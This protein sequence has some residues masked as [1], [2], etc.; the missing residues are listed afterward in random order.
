MRIILFVLFALFTAS[1]AHAGD[2]VGRGPAPTWVKAPPPAPATPGSSA[3]D[4]FRIELFDQQF[5]FDDDGSHAFVRTRAVILAPQAL[6]AF[7][8]VA[9]PWNPVT[10]DVVVHSLEVI[11]GSQRID[12]LAGKEFSLLR[13]EENLEAAIVDGLLTATLQ[14]D[15]LRVGDRVE[16]AYSVTTRVPVLGSHAE[17]LATGALPA[18]VDQYFLRGSWP[19][20][21]GLRLQ[22]SSDWTV[23]E[24]RRRGDQSEF[25]VALSGLEPLLIPDDAP[26]RFHFVRQI[27]GT[28]YGSWADLAA[29]F[30]PL[31]DTAAVLAPD[32]PLRTE[33]ARISAAYTDPSD[34]ALAALRLVQD[35]VRYL[36]LA[37]GEG[38]LIPATADETWNRRLGD[39]KGKTVLLIALL[40]ELGIDARPVLVSTFDDA[41]DARLPRVAAF[42]HVIVRAEV[43]GQV[44]W[45][46][47]ARSG[48]RSLVA[49]PPL[50]YGWVLPV[51]RTGS[52][53]VRMP[54]T[55]PDQFLR[56]TTL[57]FDL[58]G[59]LYVSGP[60][61]GEILVRGDSAVA[62]QSQFAVATQAQRDAYMRAT[63]PALV[64]GLEITEVG[65]T[66]DIERNELRWSMTGRAKLDW[67]SR[68]GRRTEI[69][70]SRI[71]W[72]AGDRRPEGPFRDLPVNTNYPG[73]SR[74]RTTIILPEDG[75][76]FVVNAVDID[77]EAAGYRHRRQVTRDG[78]RI[79]ME[80]STL[81]LRPEMTEAERAAAV[82]PLQRLGRQVAEILAPQ[83]YE[84]SAEDLNAIEDSEPQTVTDWVN[85]GLA[86]N[87]NN[88][89]AEAIA[90]FDR[91]IAL[92][93]THANAYAN[94]GI[95]RFWSGDMEGAT[96]DF[97]KA[98]ELNPSERVAMNG[99]GMIALEDERYLDAVVEFT[100]SLRAQPDDLFVLR[101][102]GSAYAGMQEWDKS[103]AD[104]A[105][106]REIRPGITE[107]DL[108]EVFVLIGAERLEEAGAAIDAVI[109]RE[110][111]SI[112]ALQAQSSV[113]ELRGDF[114]GAEASLSA[115]LAIE[116][117]DPLLLLDRA[118][119]RFKL[120]NI[121]GGRADLAIV[122]PMTSTSATLLNNICWTQAVA[123]VDLEQALADCDAALARQPAVAGF[124]DSR[125]LVLLHLGRTAEAL[126]VY[127][128]ALVIQPRQAA[129][130]YGRGLAK[131]VLG[132]VDE[133]EADRRAAERI[134]PSVGDAFET[135]ESRYP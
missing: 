48:D 34:R 73:Y 10:Q 108:Q 95:V 61:K 47:G 46:D 88:L 133:G 45:L 130:L 70:V 50:D 106:I 118:G 115:A 25:E 81:V 52:S 75:E 63:W 17:I 66:Y 24:V 120:G 60:V 71:S 26:T 76:G 99:R 124:L 83:S 42:D 51:E 78:A 127:E 96:A 74:F 91:A 16:F 33:I 14:L 117:D 59:G 112:Q 68:G 128:Q 40:R 116:R 134:D 87:S 122:R 36:A 80:R 32:S 57:A 132:R 123:G 65:S 29:V 72:S 2:A 126:E 62:M 104:L 41:L 22:A 64:D 54:M 20:A 15:D 12:A 18:V 4:A 135:F 119:V 107:I 89:R 125:G 43:D 109:Q 102:R 114:A 105:R 28:D 86:L 19:T 7:G 23:P 13:R 129:S 8:S 79:V 31:F 5:R 94:R 97:D 38:G 90:A 35:E 98:S 49:L 58:T 77:E 56:E 44:V 67:A 1:A 69:P 111:S 100:L 11:R 30:A 113:R 27:E 53:L 131:R 82:E 39:C 3:G 84:A 103:L 93:P 121:E 101:A 55:P 21:V 85:R 37:M 110:P 92:D 6:S 9:I